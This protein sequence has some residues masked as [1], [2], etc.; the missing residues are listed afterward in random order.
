MENMTWNGIKSYSNNKG[1]VRILN[2]YLGSFAF[3]NRERKRERERR[4]MRN[5]QVFFTSVFLPASLNVFTSCTSLLHFHRSLLTSLT[6]SSLFLPSPQSFLTLLAPSS[7]FSPS[8]LSLILLTSHSFTL[9][10]YSSPKSSLPS[11]SHLFHLTLLILSSHSLF[12][13]ATTHFL[14]TLFMLSSH[15]TLLSLYHILL[16]S[17]GCSAFFLVSCLCVLQTVF[18]RIFQNVTSLTS[19]IFQ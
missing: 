4:E 12:Y 3:V 18:F 15:S 5:R 14:F 9:P 7:H 13:H 11:P 10:T 8:P 17:S 1:I 2:Y 19:K 6:L 16:A